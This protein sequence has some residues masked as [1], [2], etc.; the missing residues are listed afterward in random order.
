MPIKPLASWKTWWGGSST[1]QEIACSLHHTIDPTK[2]PGDGKVVDLKCSSKVGQEDLSDFHTSKVVEG[3]LSSYPGSKEPSA[4]LLG[5]ACLVLNSM[6][7]NCLFGPQRANPMDEKARR[8]KA[9]KQGA[10]LKMLLSY[11]RSSSGRSPKGRCQTVTYLKELALS[12]GRPERKGKGTRSSASTCAS[13]ASTSST[14]SARTL[15]MGVDT[16][17]VTPADQNLGN[18]CIIGLLFT[19]LVC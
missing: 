17:P 8:T 2:L 9:L 10:Y 18:Q 12:Q 14:M 13:P 15:V 7:G 19:L 4:Y 11:A 1:A 6:M 5:D 3:L 16:D